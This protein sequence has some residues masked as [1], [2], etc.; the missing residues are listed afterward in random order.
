MGKDKALKKRIINLY[1]PA[2][3][4]FLFFTIA[5]S[6]FRGI[7]HSF[8]TKL[9]LCIVLW[10]FLTI[11]ATFAYIRIKKINPNNYPIKA[12][13]SDCLDIMVAIY[14]CAAIGGI[15]GHENELKSYL[16]LSLPFLVLSVNQ[17]CW[18]IF[19]KKFDLA[20]IFRICIL[21][22]GMLAISISEIL[23]HSV[24]NLAAVAILITLLGILRAIDKSPRKFNDFAT[25]LWSKVKK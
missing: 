22:I 24:W 4:V 8:T 20:A 16:H 10:V 18:F 14:V 15:Y 12:L 25:N 6:L 21:F 11:Q 17:F 1:Y 13:L 3:M 23:Q 2:L 9:L 19:V 5:D 7:I